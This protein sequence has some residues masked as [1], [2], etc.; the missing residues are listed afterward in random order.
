[1][2]NLRDL[3]AEARVSIRTVNRVLKNDGYVHASTRLAVE[4]AVKK[5][6]YHPNLAARALKTAKSHFIAVLTF[7]ED[8]LRMA[9]IAALQQ[10]LRDADYLV[11][12]TFQFESRQ[13]GKAT[14]TIQ[15]MIGQNPAG[16]VL[17][18]HDPYVAQYILPTL[19]S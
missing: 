6:G 16:I 14:Q 17:M 8:E 13:K 5:L 12:M 11:S 18:G 3:A 10:R 4:S 2:A 19:M 1:M 9:Q 15:E 7:T